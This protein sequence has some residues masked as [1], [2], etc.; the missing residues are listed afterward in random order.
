MEACGGQESDYCWEVGPCETSTD[1]LDFTLGL[2]FSS[3]QEQEV[4]H[5]QY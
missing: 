4:L 2:R 5:A 3:S 1:P